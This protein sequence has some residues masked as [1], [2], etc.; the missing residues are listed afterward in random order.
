MNQDQKP[1]M[2]IPETSTKPETTFLEPGEV[3]PDEDAPYGARKRRARKMK[4]AREHWNGRSREDYYVG[5]VRGNKC[6]RWAA[7]DAVIPLSVFREAHMTFAEDGA[8]TWEGHVKA[9]RIDSER[10]LAEY[11]KS[12]DGYTD[13]QKAEMRNAFGEDADDHR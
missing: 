1:T 13:V 2:E 4:R 9:E 10:R 8:V 5:E 6:L 7:N 12:H 3:L 11:R